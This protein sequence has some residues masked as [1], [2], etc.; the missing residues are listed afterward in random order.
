MT[1]TDAIL[2]AIR[3]ELEFWRPV[4]DQRVGQLDSVR[5]IVHLNPQ[6]GLPRRVQVSPER[7]RE[8]ATK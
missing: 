5:I 3:S 1:P 7:N 2:A 8:L 6:A 4:L